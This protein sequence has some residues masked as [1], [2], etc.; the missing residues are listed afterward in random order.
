MKRFALFGL[1][2]LALLPGVHGAAAEPTG[3]L[4]RVTQVAQDGHNLAPPRQMLCPQAGCEMAGELTLPSGPVSFNTVVTF[5]TGG[6]Y[7]AFASLPA[8]VARIREFTQ[9][10]PAPV[11]LPQRGVTNANVLRLAV[12]RS[13]VAGR[14]SAA[15]LVASEPDA[16]LKVELAAPQS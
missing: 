16:L 9:L 5:V 8:G 10:R 3:L 13:G 4:L 14:N 7:L 6:A 11:F 1:A 12:E 15:A 2:L